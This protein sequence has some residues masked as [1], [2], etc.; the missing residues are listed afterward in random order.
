M[1]DITDSIDVPFVDVVLNA[2]EADANQKKSWSLVSA[3]STKL[4]SFDFG[5]KTVLGWQQL[6]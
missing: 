6:T 3:K 5:S 2:S 1:F 4:V